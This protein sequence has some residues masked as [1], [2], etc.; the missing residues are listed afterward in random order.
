VAT[1]QDVLTVP[2]GWSIAVAQQVV[3]IGSIDPATHVVV[4]T[5]EFWTVD[6]LGVTGAVPSIADGLQQ[7]A[8]SHGS[9]VYGVA[10]LHQDASE[11]VCDPFGLGICLPTNVVQVE[12]YRWVIVHSQFQAVAILL[13]LLVAAGLVIAWICDNRPATQPCGPQVQSTAK[14]ALHEMCNIFG[15]GC[16]VQALG[17]VL[18]LFSIASIGLAAV[19]FAAESG[20]AQKMNLKPPQLPRIPAPVG[21]QPPRM[22][23]GVG[24]P[25]VGPQIRI[26]G[27]G[28]RRRGG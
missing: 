4:D 24:A 7:A 11:Q 1:L 5:A 22:S 16:A 17:Q 25:E 21:I 12:R 19:L 26:G 18:L 23:L 14:D 10:L 27:S 3:D 28:R 15:A 20:L 6:I 9:N 8:A 13:G 2:A